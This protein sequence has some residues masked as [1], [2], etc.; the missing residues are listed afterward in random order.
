VMSGGLALAAPAVLSVSLTDFLKN[1]VI[2][3]LIKTLA[4][5]DTLTPSQRAE[6]CAHLASALRTSPA[7]DDHGPCPSRGALPVGRQ[8]QAPTSKG[9]GR[10]HATGH[11]RSRTR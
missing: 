10:T 11:R 3:R 9:T 6:M 1:L 5:R 8:Y 7:C 4:G 2:I